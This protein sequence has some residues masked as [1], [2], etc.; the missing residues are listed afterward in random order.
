MY[1]YFQESMPARQYERILLYMHLRIF[2]CIYLFI[3]ARFMHVRMHVYLHVCTYVGRGC[4]LVESMPFNQRIA[5]SHP[6]LA[7]T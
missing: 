3:H 6:V 2:V 4:A 5:G 1:A 7:A